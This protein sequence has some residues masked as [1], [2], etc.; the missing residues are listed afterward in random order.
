VKRR[1]FVRS[2]GAGALTAGLA[3]CAREQGGSA[4]RAD[5]R[6]RNWKMVTTWPP[7]FPGL[8]TGA[9]YLANTIAAASGGRL[10]IKVYGGGE[11]VPALE[12][13][14]AVAGGSAEMGHGAAYYWKGKSPAAQF[15]GAVPFGMEP[16][17]VNGWL[18]HGGGIDLWR[19]VYARFGIVPFPTGNSGVQMG[20]WF[21]REIN[22]VADL[23]GLKMRIPGLGGDVLR[24]A[25]GTPVLLAGGDV[26]TALETGAI[27]ATEW[28]GPY[29]DL[30]FGLH[31]AARYYYYPGWHEPGSVIECIV[32]QRSYEALPDDLQA[33]VATACQAA[34]LEMLSEFTAF[35]QQAL[36]ALVE[37]HG[38]ELRRFPDE[39]L[40]HLQVLSH[41]M[42]EELAAGDATVRKVYDSYR[43][44]QDKAA[45]WQAVSELAYLQ[46]RG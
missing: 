34:N 3:A 31:K 4:T 32:N 26:Y 30:A 17:E 5:D 6:V 38:V 42:L 9:S 11:L 22:T 39:V 12:V 7:N 1:H 44:F 20:G 36:N 13:F 37:E 2:L 8:G 45:K 24:R 21:N 27:D 19:E 35:N 14:D 16:I 10:R 46:T 15:F 43:T 29:N 18:Y 23:R 40:D 25:G 41:E 33:I 28:V